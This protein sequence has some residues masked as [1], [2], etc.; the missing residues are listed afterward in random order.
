MNEVGAYVANT[1]YVVSVAGQP[2][3]SVR[4]CI[5]VAPAGGANDAYYNH[6]RLHGSARDSDEFLRRPFQDDF[7]EPP[8]ESYRPGLAKVRPRRPKP[9]LEV[10][11]EAL[12]DPATDRAATEGVDGTVPAQA[13]GPSLQQGGTGASYRGDGARGTRVAGQCSDKR[14][15]E[16]DP[17]ARASSNSTSRKEGWKDCTEM[18]FFGRRLAWN[19]I[20]TERQGLCF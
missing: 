4:Y 13:V 20:T 9:S 18:R 10:A 16:V 11:R 8:Y 7:P 5:I 12:Q 2:L 1:S 6:V 14:T 3:T 17:E 19:C 15:P